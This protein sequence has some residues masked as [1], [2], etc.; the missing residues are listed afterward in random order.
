M[1][2]K[3]IG[4]HK[5]RKNDID[6][7]RIITKILYGKKR[8]TKQLLFSSRYF[9]K[10]LASLIVISDLLAMAVNVCYMSFYGNDPQ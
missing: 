10:L 4:L 2:K 6:C 9:G 8:V 1:N 5:T 3:D 7:N